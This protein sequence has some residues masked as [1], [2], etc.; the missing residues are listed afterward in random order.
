LAVFHV[1][2]AEELLLGREDEEELTFF[3]ELLLELGREEDEELTFF[4]ELEEA[5]VPQSAT[6]V[7]L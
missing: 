5:G 2:A 4:D 6:L 7:Q 3:D 1:S